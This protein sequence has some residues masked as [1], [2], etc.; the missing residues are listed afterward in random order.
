MCTDQISAA[1]QGCWLQDPLIR[2]VMD[3]DHVS[4]R[5]MLA[6][7]ERVGAAMA[8]RREASRHAEQV[9]G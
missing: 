1:A 7:L 2:L 8:T 3:S 6:L 4:D 9:A 5:D